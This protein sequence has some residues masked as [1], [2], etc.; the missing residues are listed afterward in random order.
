[1]RG[2]PPDCL[3]SELLALCCPFAVVEKCLLIPPKR[4]AFVQLPDVAAAANLIAFYQTRDALIRGYKI[5]FEFS[6]RDEISV[7]PEF[8]RQADAPPSSSSVQ[9]SYGSQDAPYRE[10]GA[11]PLYLDSPIRQSTC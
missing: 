3:E 6:N 2:L 10:N 7:R 9:A 8:D 5:L 1:M 11:S 4:S